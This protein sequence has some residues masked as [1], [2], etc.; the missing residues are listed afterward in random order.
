MP[1]DYT[2]TLN[3]DVL[4]ALCEIGTQGTKNITENGQN[5]DVKKFAAVNVAVPSPESYTG[6]Y[7]ITE[8][9]T[10][11]IDGKVATDDI[12]VNVSGSSPVLDNESLYYYDTEED[13]NFTKINI[14]SGS[15][16]V[17]YCS[18]DGVP[19][20]T[21]VSVSSDTLYRY[22]G[23]GEFAD[24]FSGYSSTNCYYCNAGWLDPIE[25]PDSNSLVVWKGNECG[26][27]WE[28]VTLPESGQSTTIEI[29]GV[30]YTITAD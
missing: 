4:E 21:D 6:S 29:S 27:Q 3:N 13:P 18:W 28:Y 19:Q 24:P 14:K 23:Y 25:M 2:Y 20:F 8:N 17:Y 11:Y 9:G 15:N 7:N 1:K 5:I 10:I 16:A 26:V 30:T 12:V 22:G